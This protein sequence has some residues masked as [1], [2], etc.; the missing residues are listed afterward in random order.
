MSRDAEIEVFDR[1]LA[2]G[3]DVPRILLVHGPV[4]SGKST[5]LG[6]LA[7]RAADR[8]CLVVQ[9]DAARLPAEG[10]AVRRP[11]PGPDLAPTSSTD[12]R[13]WAAAHEMLD[14]RDAAGPRVLVVDAVDQE[15]GVEEALRS[16]VLPLLPED[17]VAV[18][19]SRRRPDP[20]WS[21]DPGWHSLSTTRRLR[22]LSRAAA[23]SVV[24]R[25][26]VPSAAQPGVL[27]FAS[28]NPLALSLAA[29]D[30]RGHDGPWE[31]RADLVNVLL[32]RILDPADQ[33]SHRT[34]LAV[35]AQ[36]RTVTVDLLTTVL[37]QEAAARE[38]AWLN[39]LPC[40]V[41]GPTGL[42]LNRLTTILLTTSHRWRDPVSHERLRAAAWHYHR[43]R[44]LGGGAEAADAADELLHLCRPSGWAAAVDGTGDLVPLDLGDRLPDVVRALADESLP[45]A[46]RPRLEHWLRARPG[47]FTVFGSA[48]D[49]TPVACV[50]WLTLTAAGHPDDADPVAAAAWARAV[51]RGVP[52]GGTVGLVR[53]LLSSA[54]D[55]P[56]GPSDPLVR[57]WHREIAR[58]GPALA[59]SYIAL[60]LGSA[61]TDRMAELGHHLC[62][63]PA[64]PEDDQRW[65]LF[66]H[67]WSSSP[68]AGYIDLVHELWTR[69]TDPVPPAD[70]VPG[71]D[72]ED[73]GAAVRD[74]LRH[75]S[76]DDAVAATPLARWGVV[77]PGPDPDDVRRLIRG[78]V[79]DMADE[80]ARVKHCRAVA[81]TYLRGPSTQEA[82]AARL[83][84]PFSTFRRHLAKGTDALVD[85]VC[86]RV[87]P[88]HRPGTSSSHAPA[89]AGPA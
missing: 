46:D 11:V 2:G 67:D 56:L 15:P 62:T 41:S 36:S 9:V 20:E 75:W 63:G 64:T 35:A 22:G 76:D 65:Q 87:R 84:L 6:Q 72:R 45:E 1:M 40:V 85:A 17:A 83:G 55:D 69:R 82:A 52:A 18:V 27:A 5:L 59:L 38:F 19:A 53:F 39:T 34:V 37:D 13:L 78:I 60:P 44:A 42:R 57:Q 21:T 23:R 7:D 74:L 77:D 8:G 58:A 31:P 16:S 79:K 71:P 32:D 66:E 50:A 43:D 12:A 80:P 26:G 86:S 73:V 14:A 24:D 49:A 48:E 28:G 54:P 61:M 10:P 25:R 30:A 51:D 68:L 4:G 33:L 89:P 29:D 70:E 47:A 81:T 3:P 88:T